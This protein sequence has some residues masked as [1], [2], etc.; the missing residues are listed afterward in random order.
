MQRR[1]AIFV[2][3]AEKVKETTSGRQFMLVAV[4]PG[5]FMDAFIGFFPDKPYFKYAWGRMLTQDAEGRI[6]WVCGHYSESLTQTVIEF[7]K[8]VK[9]DN[10]EYEEIMK[11]MRR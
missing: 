11:E 3:D 9:T 10:E 7:C 2:P 8:D 1:K 4:C 5:G 6:S